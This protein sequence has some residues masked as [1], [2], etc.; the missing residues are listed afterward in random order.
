MA[1]E[2]KKPKKWWRV[3]GEVTVGA[4]TYV[5]ADSEE[6]AKQRASGREPVLSPYG[7]A[8]SGD[9]PTESAIVDDADGT[10]PGS[11]P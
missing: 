8:R 3:D 7:A 11:N 6:E 10:W 5:R 9:N 1:E 2:P 4:Y